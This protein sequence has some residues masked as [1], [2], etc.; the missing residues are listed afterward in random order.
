MEFQHEE[1]KQGNNRDHYDS[2]GTWI[3]GVQSH[4]F[5]Q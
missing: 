5:K 3:N 4:A 2:F 1:H